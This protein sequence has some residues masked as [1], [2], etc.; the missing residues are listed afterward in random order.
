METDRPKCESQPSTPPPPAPSTKSLHLSAVIHEMSIA[1]ASS[2]DKNPV[3]P[4]LRTVP[5]T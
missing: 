4:A 1:A 5:G 2:V 3:L